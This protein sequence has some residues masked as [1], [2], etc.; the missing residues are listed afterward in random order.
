MA[1]LEQV[2]D[3]LN[4]GLLLEALALTKVCVRDNPSD[5]A[6]RTTLVSLFAL[7]GDFERALQQ[8][9]A[10]R[11]L[12]GELLPPIFES[13]L[14]AHTHRAAVLSG[15]S[16]PNFLDAEPSWAPAFQKALLS[17]SQTQSESELLSCLSDLNTG[18]DELSGRNENF[19]FNGFR[20]CDSR[21]APVLEGVFDGN[22]TWIPLA[23]I[24]R[25]S[26]PARPDLAQDLVW[27]PA[28][29]MLSNNEMKTGHLFSTYP[30]TAEHGSPKAMLARTVEW[31]ESLESID[32]AR[33]QQMFY[34]GE[35]PVPLFSLGQCSFDAQQEA[36]NSTLTGNE[37]A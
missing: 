30:G 37:T 27:C 14:L 19:E 4:E 24:S 17:L 16:A 20:N 5:L 11:S 29:V 2:K 31:D 36:V 21:L 13:L 10:Q 23:D 6:A 28:I 15:Q 8:Y 12:G 26:I 35:E 25:I 9:Q 7:Q 32:V 18:L 34:L 33:G 1:G 22:Y 3:C